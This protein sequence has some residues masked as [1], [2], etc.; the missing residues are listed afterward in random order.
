MQGNTVQKL[1]DAIIVGGGPAGL[2]AALV[3]G[4]C[5]R[6][7]LVCDSGE[8]RNEWSVSLNGYLTRDGIHPKEFLAIGRRELEPYGVEWKNTRVVEAACGADG[9]F[10]LVTQEGEKLNCKKLLLA[11][12]LKDYWPE[13]PG[14]RPFY[15]TSIHH[16]PYCDGWESRDK[17]LVAYGL[18][19]VAVGLSMS[20]KTWS[21]DV[22]LCTDG[23]NRLTTE[24]RDKLA[25]NGIKVR[26][27]KITRAV[28]A[29]G[30]LQELQFDK[31][32]PIPCKA[33]F[34]AMASVQRSDLPR[35]Q[36][37]RQTEGAPHGA[38]PGRRRRPRHAAGHRRRRR[39][40]QSRHPHEQ[41]ITGRILP[42][43]NYESRIAK[44]VEA[45]VIR[46]S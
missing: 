33:L 37:G 26:T 32:D 10:E 6:S 43:I 1:Y 16:C 41:G 38:L 46:D 34:F 9:W 3:L 40:R 27:E 5:R 4:R 35:Q 2:S 15:G 36:V 42:V 28:G 18:G 14:S 30:Q 31:G 22:T 24:D 44:P 45:T 23:S 20:L 17:P 13:I 29:G 7:V 21:P 39:R 12:G 8:S 11:T 19:R 25:R